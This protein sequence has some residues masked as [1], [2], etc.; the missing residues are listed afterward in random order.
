M[1][2]FGHGAVKSMPIPSRN[3]STSATVIGRSAGTVSVTEPAGSTITRRFA[4][5]GSSSSTG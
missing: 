5:S 4:N 2:G 1:I 3:S